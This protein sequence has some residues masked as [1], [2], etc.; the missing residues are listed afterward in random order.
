MVRR[1]MS[2]SQRTNATDP[3]AVAGD[4]LR[5]VDEIDRKLLALLQE[6]DRLAL[7]ELSKLIGVAASTLNDRIKRLVSH[8]LITGFHARLSS[9]ALGLH[10][11]AFILVGWSNPKVEPQFLKKIRASAAVL[12][13]HHVTGVWN[14][15]LKVRVA[16]T[17]EL[18]ALLAG[19]IK[20][21]N[22]V[23]R[24]ETLIALSTSKETW[25]LEIPQA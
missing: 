25:A 5:H 8:G 11:L 10:L 17:R 20:A 24:T 16:N 12:E 21:V 1:E 4:A 22:G 7:A 3:Q 6:N 14:Y 9:E 19:T 15:L 18:E 13:C 23:E 2:L